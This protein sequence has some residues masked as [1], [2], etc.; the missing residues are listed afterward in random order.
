MQDAS[1]NAKCM[2][3]DALWTINQELGDN[4][5]E[6][7]S[8]MLQEQFGVGETVKLRGFGSRAFQPEALIVT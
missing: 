7:L 6:S 4:L 8:Q 2:V 5:C 1:G 3:V